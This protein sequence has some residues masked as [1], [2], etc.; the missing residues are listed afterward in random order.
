MLDPQDFR[1]V[2]LV[3]RERTLKAAAMRLSVDPSTMGRR[4]ESIENRFGARLFVRTPRGFEPTP[5]GRH[6]TAAAEKIEDIEL[7][8]A[9]DLLAR[10]PARASALT[11]T[12]AE[13]GVPCLTRALVELAG[14][15]PEMQ[16]RLRIENRALDLTRREADVALRI[17]RPSERTLVGKRV[18]TV[19]YGLFASAAY[20]REHQSP[21]SVTELE[22]HH[23]CSLDQSLE[24]VPNARW[25]TSMMRGARVVFRSNSMLALLQAVR[26]GGGIAALPTMLAEAD[27]ELVRVLPS[28]DAVERSLW[29][30]FHRDLRKSRPV[31]ALLGEIATAIGPIFS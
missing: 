4:L 6:V 29:L 5:E 31:R 17:G 9:R 24:H 7:A 3:A 14:R 20:L 16:L 13:W 15:H 12:V 25:Q 2:L 26:S 1:D 21:R 28:L 19:R 23:F 8:F 30:V 27:G 11:L 10:E 18:G 22:A